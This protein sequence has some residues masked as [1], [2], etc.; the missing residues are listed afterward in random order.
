M[1]S[2]KRSALWFVS[3]CPQP[4]HQACAEL[5]C[6]CYLWRWWPGSLHKTSG[7]ILSLGCRFLYSPSF[8]K[9]L[10]A[11][12]NGQ[13]LPYLQATRMKVFGGLHP[14]YGEPIVSSPPS[15]QR[16]L[17]S[18]TSGM[19]RADISFQVSH[20]PA[21]EAGARFSEVS[22]LH[23]LI[24]KLLDKCPPLPYFLRFLSP[25]NYCHQHPIRASILILNK[26][27]SHLLIQYPLPV[28]S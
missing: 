12:H 18:R 7:E 9:E 26:K 15:A 27:R 14:A 10:V 25:P 1:A 6:S 3:A 11:G 13:E 16:E 22:R 21:V 24:R 19:R 2:C 8:T 28:T 17:K 23:L 5:H 20:S 4:E